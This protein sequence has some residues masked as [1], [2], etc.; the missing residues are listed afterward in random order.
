[1]ASLSSDSRPPSDNGDHLDLPLP[2][3]LPT[4]TSTPVQHPD[5]C[6]GLSMTLLDTILHIFQTYTRTQPG[7]TRESTKTH[8][9][10]LSIGSGTGLFEALLT[11]KVGNYHAFELDLHG[12]EVASSTTA[13]KYLPQNL[14]C[15]VPSTSSLYE[16]ASEFD[17]W[18]FVYPRDPRLVKK[19]LDH[20]C[21][22]TK[23]P[24]LV[25]FLG[26]KSDFLPVVETQDE[27]QQETFPDILGCVSDYLDECQ[28][29]MDQD[30]DAG[31]QELGSRSRCSTG[32]CKSRSSPFQASI[33]P[34]P[35]IGLTSY[36]ILC[37]LYRS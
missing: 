35:T 19:Y 13:N 14:R 11:S 33:L 18:L 30:D 8:V 4:L 2:F 26:P 32:S 3:P 25:L 10:C 20:A 5:C 31:F 21:E 24:E 12:L 36:E 28:R 17:V 15:T 16:E 6:L 9:K 29:V 37:V 22:Q 7:N 34:S 1:M 27:S 23:N